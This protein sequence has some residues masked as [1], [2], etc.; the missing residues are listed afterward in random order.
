MVWYCMTSSRLAGDLFEYTFLTIVKHKYGITPYDL[1]TKNKETKLMHKFLACDPCD[2]T[3]KREKIES[4]LHSF[5]EGQQFVHYELTNERDAKKDVSDIRLHGDGEVVNIS[6]KHNNASIRHPRPRNLYNQVVLENPVEF[7]SEYK[8]INDTF[9]DKW[10]HVRLFKN[11]DPLEKSKLLTD[12]NRLVTHH[13]TLGD[14]SSFVQFLTLSH[15]DII[16]LKWCNTT[17]EMSRLKI[18]DIT[19]PVTTKDT[20]INIGN[21]RMRLHT[22]SSRITPVLSLKYDV[23]VYGHT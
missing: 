22:A 15:K 20:F 16:H 12:V 2:F 8:T 18:P 5:F 14:T 4:F 21:L 3:L 17:K 10:K 1:F 19:G 9:Y 11:V 6:L 23:K 13:L 7:N